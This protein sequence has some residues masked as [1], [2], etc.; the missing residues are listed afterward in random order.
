LHEHS[1]AREVVIHAR[2]RK[3]YAPLVRVNSKFWNAGGIDFHFGLFSGANLTAESAQTLVSGGIEFATPPDFQ[4]AVTNGATF[5][6]NEKSEPD[7]EKWSPVIPLHAV[8]EAKVN[9][10]GLPDLNPK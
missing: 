5:T 1:D 6:L 8:P 7:W 3:Q 10:T 9:K 4:D 2:I